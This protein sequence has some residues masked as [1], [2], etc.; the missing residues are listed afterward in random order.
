MSIH[1]FEVINPCKFPLPKE[2]GYQHDDPKDKHYFNAKDKA[3]VKFTATNITISGT[4]ILPIENEG[5]KIVFKKLVNDLIAYKKA[6][7]YISFFVIISWSKGDI[8][9]L[10]KLKVKLE[11]DKKKDPLL[12]QIKNSLTA[13]LLMISNIYSVHKQLLLLEIGQVAA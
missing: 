2:F 6:S 4:T 5:Y 11:S 8:E 12:G 9:M 1:D 10:G 13:H 3:F 7:K